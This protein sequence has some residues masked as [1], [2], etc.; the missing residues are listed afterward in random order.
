M[1]WRLVFGGPSRGSIARPN[2]AFGSLPP[3]QLVE[4]C[5]SSTE[6]RVALGFLTPFLCCHS[7]GKSVTLISASK[8]STCY[9]TSQA[10]INY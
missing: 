4:V 6:T 5:A 8:L 7:H 2:S 10:R 1:T 9:L 3:E